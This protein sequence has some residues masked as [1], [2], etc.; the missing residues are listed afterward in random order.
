METFW[1]LSLYTGT[2][3]AWP[4]PGWHYICL[5]HVIL[6]CTRPLGEL[7]SAQAVNLSLHGTMLARPGQARLDRPSDGFAWIFARGA[8]ARLTNPQGSHARAGMRVAG[9]CKIVLHACLTRTA[10]GI[11]C[12]RFVGHPTIW[13]V[14]ACKKIRKS[15]KRN[16]VIGGENAVVSWSVAVL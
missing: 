3:A 12:Y 9:P 13:N 8:D 6:A 15:R 7:F 14:P 2:A 5:P 10:D 16:P 4:L 11:A 1:F